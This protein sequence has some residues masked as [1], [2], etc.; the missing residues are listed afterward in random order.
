M[1]TVTA[2]P[3][4]RTATIPNAQA[5]PAQTHE[6]AGQ[7][8]TVELD[9]LL[10]TVESIGED[11][12]ANATDCTLWDVRQMVAHLAGACAG[13]TSLAEF[14]RQYVRN[15][16]MRE[17][18]ASIDAINGLQVKDRADRTTE[19][20]I[21][22]LRAEGP[23]AIRVRQR[24]PWLVRS[25][26]LPLGPLGLA[27]IGYLTDTIYTRDWWMHRADLCRATG[28]RMHLTP[29]HDGRIVSLVLRDLARK[30]SRDGERETVDL[31][32]WD[33]IEV[34]YRF[35]A[36]SEPDAAIS[37]NLIEFN[38]LASERSKFEDAIAAAEWS[39]DAEAAR[40]FLRNCSIPY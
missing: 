38:R 15:P 39:G 17:H 33:D 11:T 36:K 29:E 5:I 34:T 13:H 40:S 37:M 20:L 30:R 10:A 31:T 35:G 3:T 1:D 25:V 26:R 28:Q 16:L 32:L 22:E 12:W 19:E 8:A 9:R 2:L 27:P 7:L 4:D 24:I 21:D 23:K 18:D 14:K 6:E